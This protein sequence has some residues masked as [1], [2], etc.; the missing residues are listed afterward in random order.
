[1][2]IAVSSRSDAGLDSFVD[3]RFGRCAFYTII[4]VDAGTIINVQSHPNTVT[5]SF[6]VAGVQAIKMIVNIGV[7]TV[8]TGKLGPK[9]FYGLRDAEI[10]AYS[11]TPGILVSQALEMFLQKKLSLITKFGAP[12]MGKRVT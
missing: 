4:E 11:A 10:P 9:S 1:M 8:I 5:T 2:I 3:P 6:F 12:H 7:N